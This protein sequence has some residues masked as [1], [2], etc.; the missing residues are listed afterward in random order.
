[1][2]KFMVKTNKRTNKN[3]PVSGSQTLCWCL[4]VSWGVVLVFKEEDNHIVFSSK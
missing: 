1:M 2:N 3:H 4:R